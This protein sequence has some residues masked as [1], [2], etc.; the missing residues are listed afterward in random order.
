MTEKVSAFL[1]VVDWVNNSVSMRVLH[2][3]LMGDCCLSLSRLRD[4]EQFAHE[5]DTLL[6][7]AYE[8]RARN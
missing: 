6:G 7:W 8:S 3:E 5:I 4:L 2:D 1:D